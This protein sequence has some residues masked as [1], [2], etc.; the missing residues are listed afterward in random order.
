[1][2]VEVPF[3]GSVG[4]PFPLTLGQLQPYTLYVPSGYRP[5]TPT[6]LTLTR[7]CGHGVSVVMS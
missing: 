1:L 5:G 4:G 3:V 6:P 2:P 7:F